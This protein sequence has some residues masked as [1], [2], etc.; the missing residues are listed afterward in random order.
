MSL[1]S[2]LGSL[3]LPIAGVGLLVAA[4]ATRQFLSVSAG[5]PESADLVTGLAMVVLYAL[6]LV[7]LAVAALGL[8]IPPG[9]GPGVRF[10]RWQRR[11]FLGSAAAALLSVCAPLLAWGIVAGTG[12][13]FGAVGWS[14]II[15]LGGAVAALVGALA[16]RAGE[17]VTARL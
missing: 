2:S 7:G 3:Q 8:A 12:L 1:R 4:W 10:N 16:W 13:G 17:A 11:L 15:L 14:W 9:E 5:G 6:A